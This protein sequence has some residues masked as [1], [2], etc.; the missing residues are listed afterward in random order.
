[1]EGVAVWVAGS[2]R[3]DGAG[4]VVAGSLLVDGADRV[5]PA[6][7]PEV[8]LAEAAR[9]SSD[10]TRALAL[11][12]GG[13]ARFSPAR[14]GRKAPGSQASSRPPMTRRASSP[15]VHPRIGR[16][17]GGAGGRTGPL[18][19]WGG[20]VSVEGS[21]VGALAGSDAGAP[22]GLLPAVTMGATGV[23]AGCGRAEGD[24]VGEPGMASPG[25]CVERDSEGGG[26]WATLTSQRSQ[27]RTLEAES[28]S[29]GFL[30]SSAV[31]SASNGP[32]RSIGRGSSLTT[33]ASVRTKVPLSNGG[34]PSTAKNMVAPSA[35]TSAAG[36]LG[37]PRACS[38]A[39]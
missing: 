18:R 29:A 6:P 24:R 5:A 38:G 16:R 39:R 33:A 28:R 22:S 14:S 37:L 10:S 32:A 13:A 8:P 7:P 9:S 30:A 2:L 20:A 25:A 26:A 31:S 3:V 1:V 4:R 23:V 11:V 34:W 12:V 21:T 36:P 35:H 19:G 27:I 17:T 15:A